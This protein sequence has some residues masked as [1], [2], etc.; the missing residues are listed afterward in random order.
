MDSREVSVQPTPFVEFKVEDTIQTIAQRFEQQVRRYPDRLAIKY[1]NRTLTYDELNSRANRVAHAILKHGCRAQ[2]PIALVCGTALST[3]VTSFGALKAGKAFAPL[4]PR[5][6]LATAKQILA[7]L[8]SRIVLTDEK[9]SKLA[10]EL[11]MNSSKRIN[12]DNLTAGG[13]AENPRVKTAPDSLAYINFTSGSTGAPKGVMW[14]HRSELF[15]IRTKTNALQVTA[16]DRVSLLRAHNVGAARDMFLALLNGAALI[17]LDLDD[18]GLAALAKW[19]RAEEVSI[20]TCVATVFRHAVQGLSGG[21]NFPAVRLIHIGG[22]PIFKA[23]VE[24]YKRHFSDDCLFVSRY[25]ISETQAVS[26]F[27]I[28]KQTE[29]CEDRVPVGYPLEGNEVVILDDGGNPAGPREIGEIAIQSPYLATGYW[30]QPELTRAKFLAD[31]ADDSTRTYLTGDLGYRLSDGCLVHAG[32]KDFQ[33]KIRGHRVEMTAVETALREIPSIEQAIVV[34]KEDPAGRDRLIA[35]VVPRQNR[36]THAGQWRAQMKAR[37]PG[38][39]VPSVFVSLDR[40]P[41]NAGGKIDRRALPEPLAAKRTLTTPAAVPQTAVEKV[42]ARFWSDAL[43]IERPGVRDDFTE[44]GGDSLRAAQIVGRIQ[45]LFTLA[46][47]L[48][49][50]AQ[51]PTIA[52]SA[53]FIVE[54]ETKSGQSEKIATV[55]LQVESLSAGEV[56]AALENYKNPASDAEVQ[57]DAAI[58]RARRELLAR[59]LDEEGIELPVDKTAPAQRRAESAPL[60]FSQERLWFLHQL[61]PGNALYNIA[62]ALRVKGDLDCGAIARGFDA[63]VRRHEI[64]R[65][66]FPCAGGEPV[67]Q[68]A[69]ELKVDLPLTDLRALSRSQRRSGMLRILAEESGTPFD[70]ERGPLIKACLIKLGKAEHVLLVVSHQIVCDGWSMDLLL[71]E[72]EQLYRSYIG[73]KSTRLPELKVQYR[74]YAAWQREH[75]GRSTLKGQLEYWQARLDNSASG[76][77]FVTDHPRPAVQSFRGARLP[78]VIPAALVRHLQKLGRANGAT[79]FMVLMAAFNVMLWRYSGQ[80]EISVGFPVAKRW[81]AGNLI[82]FFVN[83]LVL[84]TDLSGDPDF[85]ELLRRVR[86]HCRGAL[87][88]QDLPFDKLVEEL[89]RE[90][91]LSRNPLFQAMFAYRNYPAAEFNVPGLKV[92][93][94]ELETTTAKFDL[95]LSLTERGS[96]LR[97]FIEYATDLFDGSTIARMARHFITLLRAIIADPNQPIATLPLLTEAERRQI[98]VEWN[99]TGANYPKNRCVH[100]LFEA[101]AK[102]VPR[103]VAVECAGKQWTYGEL[104]GRANQL[105]RF[106]RKRGVGPEKLAGVCL[107]RS[108]DMVIALMAILKSGG[109]YLPLDPKYPRERIAFMLEDAQASVLVTQSQ[110]AGKN[111]LSLIDRRSRKAGCEVVCLDNERKEIG[112]ESSRNVS[113]SVRSRNLAYVIYTSGSTGRPKGVAIEHRNAVAFLQWTK[114][115][116]SA[117]ELAGVL[118][119]TSICFDLSV[120]ELFAPLS[121]GGKIILVEDALAAAD[122]LE[123]KDITLINTVPSA[124]NELLAAVGLPPSIRAVNLAGEPL[125]PELVEQLY[126]TGTVDKVYDL[127]GPSETTTYSTFTRRAPGSRATI[128]RPI[129][130]TKIYLLDAALQPVPIGVPGEIFIGGAG[131]A[132]GYLHRPEVTAEKFLPDPFA[133]RCGARMYRTGDVARYYPDGDIE[134]LG[135]ADNQVKI[136]GYRIEP[137]EIEAALAEHPAVRESVVVARATSELSD[138][139]KSKIQNQKSETQL[140]AYFVPKHGMLPSAIELRKFLRAKLPEFM[141]PSMVM[142]LAALPRTPNGKVD[143]LALPGFDN[144]AGGVTN[145]F[146]APRTE[147][148]EMIA[149]TWREVLKIERIGVFDDF[150]EIGGHSLLAT[151]VVVRLRASFHAELPLRK[152]FEARTV[153]GLA[154]EIEALRRNRSGVALPG[155]V[156]ARRTDETPLSFAQQRLWFLHKLDPDLTAYNMPAAYRIEGPVKI[157]L[158][159]QALRQIIMRHEALRSAIVE[160]GGA[161]MQ[162]VVPE[163]HLKLPVIDLTSLSAQQAEAEIT[164]YFNE[165]AGQPFDLETAP[166]LRAKIIRLGGEDHVLLLN[167]HHIICDGSSLAVFYRELAAL[168]E[169]PGAGREPALPELPVQYADFAVWQQQSLHEG[170]FQTQME[171]W[172]RQLGSGLRPLDLPADRQRPVALSYRGAKVTQRLSHGLAAALKQLA[173]SE[174]VTLFMV[175]LAA[176]KVLLARL[177]GQNDIVVGSTIAGR[178]RP[179]LEGLIGFFINALALRTDLSGDPRFVE[180]LTRVRE[181]CLDA[182]THQDLPFERVVEELNPDRDPSRNPIFQVLF[183]MADASERELKLAGCAVTR[184]NR[185]APGAKFDMVF[186]AAES[187]GAIELALVYNADLFAETRAQNML[188]QWHHLLGQIVADPTERLDRFSLVPPAAK[189]LLPN[190]AERLDDSWHG[191]IQSWVTRHAEE[192]PDKQAVVDEREGWTYRE[193]DRLSHRLAERL[194]RDGVQ[195]KNVVAIYAHRDASLA[196][197]LLGIVKA[198]AVFV[199]LDPAYPPARLA[200]YLRAAQPAGLVQMDDAGQLPAELE[201]HVAAAKIPVRVTLPRAKKKIAQLLGRCSSVAPEAAVAAGDPAYIAFTSGSTGEPKGVVCRHGPMTHFLPWQSETF[202]LRSLDRYGLLSG[203]GYNHLHRDVFTALALGATLCVPSDEDLQD[204]ERLTRWLR[205]REISILHLTPALGRF[206]QT[207]KGKVLPSIRRVFFGGDLLLRRDVVAMRELAPNAQA[208]SFYGATETQRAVGYFLIPDELLKPDNGARQVIPTGRGAPGVQLLL[209]TPN[210]QLAGIGEIGEL[211]VRSPH[212]AAGYVDD[213]ELSETNF[214]TNPF[215]GDLRDRLYRTREL[216]RYLPDGNVEWLGR[217]ERRAGIRGFRVELAEVEAA[218]GQCPGVRHAAVI[219]RELALEGAPPLESRLVAYVESDKRDLVRTDALREFLNARLPP[220]MIPSY[221]HSIERM[222][223]NPNGKIDY[224]CLPQTAGLQSRAGQKF[225]APQNDLERALGKIFEDVLQVERIGRR[226]NFFELGGHSLLAAKAAARIRETLGRQLELREFLE[227]PT[228]EAI[229]RRIETTARVDDVPASLQTEEREEIEL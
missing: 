176:L 211:Y 101:Q 121:R 3:I 109:A 150:F 15:G 188:E 27:F 169:S 1:N 42:L 139:P 110:F 129:A 82:G 43:G 67:Q 196:L 64:L 4:D 20:F 108:L 22:E 174:H 180:L 208:V 53:R 66:V 149:Q 142:P 49:T 192:T 78:F 80:D 143:R 118:A 114:S 104:N 195:P 223:L 168:Y 37:L 5:L 227:I 17:T 119:S 99:N 207:A 55:F 225:E 217:N 9:S 79:P 141:L 215:T 214:I 34:N 52:D 140:L 183:N 106:L 81:D 98:L 14:N 45:G 7:G 100:Q 116:F 33:A 182:Y 38:Y 205:R 128:G 185:S 222:P 23:D 70:L 209:L 18:S 166:L 221:F 226:D 29:L 115:V 39:M 11:A 136:R 178:N 54:H 177:G 32:R 68:V 157:A 190:P 8:E 88:H 184:L 146:V 30:R 181:V 145:D 103:A 130:N 197:A 147:I 102:R 35:Y 144:G 74:D 220:Y 173:R 94:V 138:N 71:R 25:S 124:M 202:E 58:D 212:L 171:Y 158:V 219:T 57:F 84:R 21:D 165:D 31:A 96:S 131:V 113:S 63:I 87:A 41:V 159:E 95:M 204:P 191:P 51:A 92:E 179:E 69:R 161:A 228:V 134:Y 26:Y 123:R 213:G 83:T 203:L 60:S 50:L 151:R 90:R 105:A 19:L 216:G 6:P 160:I 12:I 133:R 28:N 206:L 73:V 107:E 24:L 125:R 93:S 76:I 91:D 126:A 135:R 97:G 167:F 61:D 154:R 199:I 175:L 198:G 153:A 86:E 155:I 36:K 56:A 112:K 111:E 170:R 46:R 218:L 117:A 10:R 163:A 65:T 120:F 40:L 85:H 77:A 75:L 224:A 47:A 193:L 72:L 122:L 16:G 152:L 164:R 48:V 137:G 194:H 229:C 62:R 13:P 156:P 186:H 44:M 89:Q 189:A 201:A 132:R 200:V 59:L 2:A 162:K 187:G 172:M 127:Y 210:G 148:E